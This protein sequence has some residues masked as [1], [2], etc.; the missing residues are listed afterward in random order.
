M[1]QIGYGYGSEWQ[2]LRFLGHQLYF[3]NGYDK[4]V[5]K[6]NKLYQTI[7]KDAS[8]E[9]FEVAIAK[10]LET[11]SLKDKDLSNLLTDPV[12]IDCAPKA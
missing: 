11:L 5:L 9:D 12:F 6:E 1:T 4:R 8:K 10:E 3:V 7:N 2:P